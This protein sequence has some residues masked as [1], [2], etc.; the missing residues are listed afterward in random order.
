MG[1]FYRERAAELRK[2]A[3]EYDR[4]ADALAVEQYNEEQAQAILDAATPAEINNAIAHFHQAGHT[5]TKSDDSY[6]SWSE[7]MPWSWATA[8]EKLKYLK[9][10]RGEA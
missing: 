10:A 9:I 3:D 6:S 4:L 2:Q 1:S 5:I 7:P 8:T